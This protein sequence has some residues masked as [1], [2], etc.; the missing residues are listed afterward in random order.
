MD[1]V[2][3]LGEAR[4]RHYLGSPTGLCDSFWAYRPDLLHSYNWLPSYDV[5]FSSAEQD[6]RLYLLF[7]L[8]FQF[9]LNF[10]CTS[11]FCVSIPVQVVSQPVGDW[12][13]FSLWFFSCLFFCS[14]I[15]SCS[16]SLLYSFTLCSFC[17]RRANMNNFCQC[18]ICDVNRIQETLELWKPITQIIR[19]KCITSDVP[20]LLKLSNTNLTALLWLNFSWIQCAV[21]KTLGQQEG[22]LLQFLLPTHYIDMHIWLG[23]VINEMHLKIFN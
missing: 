4:P 23:P 19:Q 8:L 15:S 13:G 6:K 7:Y 2:M 14:C 20:E 10:C 17:I 3:L 21:V 9:N 18:K 16:L 1:S 11:I 22:L 12:H 5:N